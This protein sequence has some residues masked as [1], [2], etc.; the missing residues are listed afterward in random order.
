MR[1]FAGEQ[2]T[3]L[4]YPYVNVPAGMPVGLPMPYQPVM[5][6]SA[7]SDP[8]TKSMSGY[9][10]AL[11]FYSASTVYPQSN[12]KYTIP[13]Q[14][15]Q[16]PGIIPVDSSLCAGTMPA[17]HDAG[18]A[19][20]CTKATMQGS[21]DATHNHMAYGTSPLPLDMHG[22]QPSSTTGSEIECEDDG[23]V[24]EKDRKTSQTDR[25]NWRQR[26]EHQERPYRGG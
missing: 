20:Y 8:R 1:C 16:Q 15:M 6:D 23:W 7:Q 3:I 11:P 24:E 21:G 9:V 22:S 17:Y 13:P 18:S 26:P 5:G 14:M 12:T 10:S 4:P 25:Q 2:E 19:A